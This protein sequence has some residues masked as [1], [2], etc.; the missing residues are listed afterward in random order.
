MSVMT[1]HLRQSTHYQTHPQFSFKSGTVVEQD[2][3]YRLYSECYCIVWMKNTHNTPVLG[4][5]K[6]KQKY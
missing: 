1:Y 2:L 3:H 4:Y 6:K 5:L